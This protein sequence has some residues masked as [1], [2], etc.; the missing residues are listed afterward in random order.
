MSC[1]KQLG[2]SRSRQADRQNSAVKL[3]KGDSDGLYARGRAGDI[4][5]RLQNQN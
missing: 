2:Q 5:D 1:K 3:K 4:L